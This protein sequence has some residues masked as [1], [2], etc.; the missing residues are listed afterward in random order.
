MGKEHI[1]TN[2]ESL[3]IFCKSKIMLNENFIKII[4]SVLQISSV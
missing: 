4:F 1:R 3:Q 2:V